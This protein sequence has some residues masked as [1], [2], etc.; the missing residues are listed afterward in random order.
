MVSTTSS[1]VVL[2]PDGR[3]VLPEET[4]PQELSEGD[5]SFDSVVEMLAGRTPLPDKRESAMWT[6]TMEVSDGFMTTAIEDTFR[7]KR[8]LGLV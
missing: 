8:P 6:E 7:G 1:F 3:D 5:Q 4:E 2:W